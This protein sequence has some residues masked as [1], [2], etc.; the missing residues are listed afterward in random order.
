MA[1][2]AG[3]GHRR[4]VVV[5][6]F[7]V[8][9]RQANHHQAADTCLP[10]HERFQSARRAPVAVAKGVHR[11]DMVVSGQ[12]LNNAVVF[13]K[14]PGNRGAKAAEGDLAPIAT[15]NTAAARCAE[16][17]VPSCRPQ[18]ARLAMVVIATGH[19]AAVDVKYEFGSNGPVSRLGAQ[20]AI[21]GISRPQLALRPRKVDV[22]GNFARQGYFLFLV[23]ELGALDTRGAGGLKP[24]LFLVDLRNPLLQVRQPVQD[25]GGASGLNQLVE[26]GSRVVGHPPLRQGVEAGRFD[27][28]FRF[29]SKNVQ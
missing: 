1:S 17:N 21:R 10:Q 6:M 3:F 26:D 27:A 20:P 9:I 8:V 28:H 13:P 19:H 7:V 11:T 29:V 23:A 5:F 15:F 16:R 25:A 2:P 24:Q 14:F 12:G 22:R 18:G 4:Q